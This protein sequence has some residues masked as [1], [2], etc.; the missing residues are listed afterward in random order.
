MRNTLFCLATFSL[1]IDRAVVARGLH[2]YRAARGRRQEANRHRQHV[3]FLIS[4]RD[5]CNTDHAP[6]PRIQCVN[7]KKSEVV[8]LDSRYP[9]S[10]VEVS[11]Q[12]FE[13]AHII[14]MIEPTRK[15]RGP[16]ATVSL[17]EKIGWKL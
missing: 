4:L 9:F 11:F 5:E 14:P 12:N 16:C 6:W 3:T 10:I 2:G 7:S 13:E 1:E 15:F 8:R 17:T